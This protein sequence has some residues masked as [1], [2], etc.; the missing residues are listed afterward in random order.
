MKTSRS[1][2][3]LKNIPEKRIP[4]LNSGVRPKKSL[5]VLLISR[6]ASGSSH[7]VVQARALSV[8]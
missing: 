6:S 7:E 4:R 8:P 3:D 2:Y 5:P 1:I